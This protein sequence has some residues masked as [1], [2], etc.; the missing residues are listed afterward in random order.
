M[1][2][3]TYETARRWSGAVQR[4]SRFARTGGIAV[5]LSCVTVSAAEAGTVTLAW[6]RNPETN[7][8]GYVL[9]Y[10]FG[11][12]QY[13]ASIN[14]GNVVQYVFNEPEADR[15]YFFAL[16]AV[17]TAGLGGG[18]SSEVNNARHALTDVL[19]DHGAQGLW[20]LTDGGD[21]RQVSGGN[22]TT[23][24]TGDLDGNAVDEVIGDFGAGEGIWIRWNG[25]TWARLNGQT[26]IGMVTGD[27][28]NN[29][30]DELV[31]NFPNAGVWVFWNGGTWLQLHT[32][33]PTRMVVGNIEAGGA[34]LIL[35]YPGHG[36]WIRR[37]N[38]TWG[39][40]HSQSSTA[41]A[42]GD[43]DGDGHDDVAIEFEG[44]GVWNLMNGSSWRQVTSLQPSKL[45]AGN[46]DGNGAAVLLAD[47]APAGIWMLR[48]GISWTELHPYPA[49]QFLFADVDGDGRDE[50]IID[51]GST[52]GSWIWNSFSG[53]KLITADSPE[54]IVSGSFN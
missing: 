20:A 45:A 11:P 18:L 19:F 17:N 37:N 41:M 47:F 4:L 52:V 46:T 40:V 33:N 30:R 7:I 39:Q 1:Q 15:T 51:F 2:G 44:A 6:D 49:K 42:V 53:W 16:Q 23:L 24:I 8:G 29:G 21:Y 48:N 38:D 36:I 54:T 35:D 27:L 9:Y 50:I 43:F 12:D 14:V 3:R 31:V 26:V 34:A 22:P 32:L 28:D 25:T 10:G 5:A 13:T